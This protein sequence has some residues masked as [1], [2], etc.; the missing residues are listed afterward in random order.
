MKKSLL[1]LIFLGLL[2][3][4]NQSFACDSCNF[5]EYSLL[6]NKSYIGLFYRFRDF[7]DYKTISPS[8]TTAIQS[9]PAQLSTQLQPWIGNEIMHEPEGNNLYVQKTK[10]DFE[11]YQ[12]IEARGNITLNYKWNLTFLLP[13]EFNK[14]YYEK[15]LDLPNPVSDTTLYVQGWGDLTTAVEY[16]HL[17]YNPK[18]RHTFRPGLAFTLP[19]GQAQI[20][21]NNENR[22]LFDPIIQPGKGA[23]SFIPRL[24]YQW[25]LENKGINAGMSYQWSTEGKQSY[26][27]GNSFNA[28]LLYFHQFEL[29]GSL[30]LAPNLGVYHESAQRDIYNGEKQDLT[31]GQVDFA[32]LG[33]DLNLSQTTFSLVYQRPIHQN[34]NGNQILNQHRISIG[35]IRSFKL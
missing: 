4:S 25:F 27:F 14:V 30:L 1:I 19:T 21:S 5:F 16:I 20:Q 11:T 3:Q 10:Q 33:L 34:L 26:Q 9:F 18:S 28:Y 12:T 6:E 31:G 29:G 2:S 23:F 7:R 17:V 13:Y 24:N 8:T 32:Q 22:E 35:L 15:Y